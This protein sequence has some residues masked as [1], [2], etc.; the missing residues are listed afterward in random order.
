MASVNPPPLRGLAHGADLFSCASLVIL[1]ISLLVFKISLMRNVEPKL[2]SPKSRAARSTHGTSHSLL[3]FLVFICRSRPQAWER[4]ISPSTPRPGHREREPVA[5]VLPPRQRRAPVLSRSV[6]G[7]LRG[8]LSTPAPIFPRGVSQGSARSQ[9]QRCP[10]RRACGTPQLLGALTFMQQVSRGQGWAA[11]P[12]PQEPFLQVHPGPHAV[13]GMQADRELCKRALS[14]AGV[15]GPP[16]CARPQEATAHVLDRRTGAG[17]SLPSQPQPRPAQ[18]QSSA[19]GQ[20]GAT[21]QSMAGH[22]CL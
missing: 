12:T 5:L 8:S 15:H 13:S 17:P 9:A 3:V 6:R 20:T 11:P 21:A 14:T 19:D 18:A 1:F 10:C 4:T 16:L 2:A 7:S 22:Q